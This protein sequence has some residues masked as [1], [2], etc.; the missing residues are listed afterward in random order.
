M[1]GEKMD[2][3]VVSTKDW[4]WHISR[5]E[6]HPL[7]CNTYNKNAK[8]GFCEFN[9]CG[10][11]CFPQSHTPWTWRGW[12]S[13]VPFV[14]VLP[15]FVS[16]LPSTGCRQLSLASVLPSHAK[17]TM[18]CNFQQVINKKRGEA[19][20]MEWSGMTPSWAQSAFKLASSSWQLPVQQF[21]QVVCLRAFWAP[22]G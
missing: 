15:E 3:F 7:Q 18:W 8:W 1:K 11:K 12:Q 16:G 10:Y 5:P 20:W 22:K 13:P 9:D 4:I 19:S 14:P 2:V 6:L 21:S 17:I